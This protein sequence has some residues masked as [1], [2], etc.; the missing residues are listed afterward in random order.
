MRLNKEVTV[1]G[2]LKYVDTVVNEEMEN[3]RKK[4]TKEM[5]INNKLVKFK[6][7][8]G[9]ECNALERKR[10]N[11]KKIHLQDTYLLWPQDSAIG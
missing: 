6:R 10:K 9:A 8:T 2:K 11:I 3:H 1:D 4:L 5:K 7:H